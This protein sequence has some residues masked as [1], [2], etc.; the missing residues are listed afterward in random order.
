MADALE[1][2]AMAAA[3]PDGCHRAVGE[4]VI[5]RHWLVELG[6]ALGLGAVATP[7]PTCPRRGGCEWADAL[8]FRVENDSRLLRAAAIKRLLQARGPPEG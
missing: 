2:E 8:D 6:S 5:S 1:A 7:V 3:A 4:P